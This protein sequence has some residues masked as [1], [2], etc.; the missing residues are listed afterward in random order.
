MPWFAEVDREVPCGG[1]GVS[2]SGAY[3]KTPSTSRRTALLLLK[4]R[5]FREVLRELLID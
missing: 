1:I 2:F 4:A 3:F 5:D